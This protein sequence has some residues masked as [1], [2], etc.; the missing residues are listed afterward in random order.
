[1]VP[2]CHVPSKIISAFYFL[3]S[4]I[5]PLFVY[6]AN[7]K[8]STLKRFVYPP[9]QHF[10]PWSVHILT[11]SHIYMSAPTFDTPFKTVPKRDF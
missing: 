6:V 1:M 9:S 11:S 2:L 3:F 4:C 7:F 5:I 10:D 8:P